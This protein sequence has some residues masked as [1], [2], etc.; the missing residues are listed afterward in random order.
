MSLRD[1][2]AGVLSR[3]PRYT[4]QAYAFIFEALE[5]TKNLKRRTPSRNRGKPRSDQ[6]RHVTGRELC[7][8]A[9]RLALENFGMMSLTVLN[10][11]GLRSTGDIGEV[12]YNLIGSGDFEKTP[13]DSRSDFDDVY[14]FEEAFRGGF[15]MEIDEAA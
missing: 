6:T 7:E 3:D 13:T 9:R 1:D 14:E 8:G 4:I 12:V 2:L 5:F 15:V 10:L 11:W